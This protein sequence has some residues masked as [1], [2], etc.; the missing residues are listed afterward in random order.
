[1]RHLLRQ[2]A[3]R[4]VLIA[5]RGHPEHDSGLIVLGM[6]KLG[7]ARA[8]LFERYRPHPALRPGTGAGAIAPTASQP[9]FSRLAHELVRMLDERT[10]DGYVFRTDLRLRPDPGST[11]PAMSVDGGARL[12]RERRARIGSARR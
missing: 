3:A 12:L 11:P 6:G 10:G 5:R 8:Q 7:G 1:M 2:A 4:L 9:F